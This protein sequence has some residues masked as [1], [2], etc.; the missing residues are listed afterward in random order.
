MERRLR[1]HNGELVGGARITSRAAAAGGVWYVAAHV[2]GFR[3]RHD[4]LS[5]EATVKLLKRRCTS[6]RDAPL[7]RALRAAELLLAR[8]RWEGR[9]CL[10][11]CRHS[12]PT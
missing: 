6:R 12:A 8:P 5:F 9:L 3:S 2:E 4:A 11:L 10:Y 7:A 1:Q